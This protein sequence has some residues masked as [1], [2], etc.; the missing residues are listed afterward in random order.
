MKQCARAAGLALAVV[1]LVA[2]GSAGATR[3]VVAEARPAHAGPAPA[4]VSYK[5]VQLLNTLPGT[6]VQAVDVAQVPYDPN[7]PPGAAPAH[8]ELRFS[9]YYSAL[10]PAESVAKPTVYV[11]RTASFAAYKWDTIEHSLAA[12]L[13]GHP[14]LTKTKLLPL[15]PEMPAGQVFHVQATYQSVGVVSVTS[16]TMP[17]MS[18]PSPRTG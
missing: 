9:H 17:R 1:L 11:F 2:A 13:R 14:D 4:P 10:F 18:P 16:P 8:I 15:L 3:T 7:E 6:R 12:I 5:N